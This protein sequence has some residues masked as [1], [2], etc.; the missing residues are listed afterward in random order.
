MWVLWRHQVV[1]Y[2]EQ[3]DNNKIPKLS[4]VG[5]KY[6]DMQMVV[7]LPRYDLSAQYCRHLK[8]D[9]QR[10]SFDE[11]CHTRNAESLDVGRV[12]TSVPSASVRD[13]HLY[14][15]IIVTIL[16]WFLVAASFL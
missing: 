6:H 13:S 10:Q 2:M 8:T 14:S 16:G 5:K 9:T 3:L 1:E 11:F 4:S 7:Q 12:I 15:F